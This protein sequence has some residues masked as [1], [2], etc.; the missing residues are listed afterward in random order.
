MQG[1]A[2]FV[3]YKE[4]PDC[5]LFVGVLT[6]LAKCCAHHVLLSEEFCAALLCVQIVLLGVCIS[7]SPAGGDQYEQLSLQPM[8]LYSLPS[9]NVIMTCVASSAAGRLF[10]GGSDG[11]LYEIQYEATDTWW[12]RRCSKVRGSSCSLQSCP[13]AATA[14]QLPCC[15]ASSPHRS[16]D[17][18]SS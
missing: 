13:M 16:V 4:A 8:P 9:D 18:A 1:K 7:P 2:S 6:S 11:N 17:A 12:Q 15:R 14:V 5:Q 3:P 10:M